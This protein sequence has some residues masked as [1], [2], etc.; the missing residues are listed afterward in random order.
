MVVVAAAAAHLCVLRPELPEKLLLRAL[1]IFKVG[2]RR[3]LFVPYF[4]IV[5][6][7]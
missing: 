2:R 7:A 5:E 6:K 3:E 4:D 1:R